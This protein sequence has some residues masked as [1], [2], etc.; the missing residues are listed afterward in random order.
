MS[1]LKQL[2][3]AYEDAEAKR[4][5]LQADKD[6]AVEKARARYAGKLRAAVDE[7]A[8]VQKALI[9]AEA[10]EALKDRPDGEKVAQALGLSLD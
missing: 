7:A 2:R 9:D 3:K 4:A 10:A 8:A 6:E 5:K 1:D